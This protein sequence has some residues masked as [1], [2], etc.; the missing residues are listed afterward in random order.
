[1]PAIV[2]FL[3]PQ[4]GV[5]LFVRFAGDPAIVW[6]DVIHDYVSVSTKMDVGT[7]QDRFLVE[8]AR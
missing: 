4:I 8:T 3:L 5:A 7:I 2:V 6:V 1:M